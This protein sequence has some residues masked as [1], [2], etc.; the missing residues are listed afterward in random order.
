MQECIMASK[1]RPATKRAKPAQGKAIKRS[2]GRATSRADEWSRVLPP[3]E[4][5]KATQSARQASREALR[6]TPLDWFLEHILQ[7][8]VSRSDPRRLQPVLATG[9]PSTLAVPRDGEVRTLRATLGLT[10]AE[11]AGMLGCS[12]RSLAK[13]ESSP[14][15]PD[16]LRARIREINTL[17]AEVSAM[18][19]PSELREWMRAPIPDMQGRTPIRVIADGD[20]IQLFLV[21]RHVAMGEHV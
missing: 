2:P 13:Y 14:Q 11:M 7:E 1:H 21:V 6:N 16:W 10:Q 17:V 20:A 5:G 12:I 8:L 4:T 9:L 18:L 15:I 19:T 3:N